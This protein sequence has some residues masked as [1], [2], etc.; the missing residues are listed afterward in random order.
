MKRAYFRN[1]YDPL[2][3]HGVGYLDKSSGIG[4]DDIFAGLAVPLGCCQTA[5]VDV[6]QESK[7]TMD[8]QWLTSQPTVADTEARII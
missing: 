6:F 5:A 4:A 3:D 7:D 2:V 8:W 1:L